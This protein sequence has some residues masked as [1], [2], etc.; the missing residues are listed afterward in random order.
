MRCA[1]DRLHWS[2]P[3][4]VPAGCG[5]AHTPGVTGSPRPAWSCPMA[6]SLRAYPAHPPLPRSTRRHATRCLWSCWARHT[7]EGAA[8]SHLRHRR[9]NPLCDN[10]F[11]SRACLHSRRQPLLNRARRTLKPHGIAGSVMSTVDIG[12]LSPFVSLAGTIGPSP[13]VGRPCRPGNG[14]CSALLPPAVLSSAVLVDE[15]E[16]PAPRV[17]TGRLPVAE[18]PVEERVRCAVVD[19]VLVLRAGLGE[20]AVKCG[21]VLR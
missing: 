7:T 11:R 12:T 4:S 2:A 5:S 18:A 20:G 19:H 6:R 10:R 8:T 9:P 15:T 17:R 1:V 16:H 14:Q 21:V 13:A 3:L